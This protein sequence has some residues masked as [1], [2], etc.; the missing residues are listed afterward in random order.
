MNHTRFPL[1][2]AVG[3]LV[4]EF[5][6]DGLC[7][8]RFPARRP[9]SSVP[10]AGARSARPKPGVSRW[11]RLAQDAV[12]AVLAGRKPRQLPPLDLSA[13]TEFQ[14]AVWR[15][16]AEIPAGQTRTYAQMAGRVG[17]PAAARAVGQA[18]GANPIPL[19]IPCHRVLAAQGRLGGFSA[20][21]EWKRLLL[22]REG[23]NPAGRGAA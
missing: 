12:N 8:L 9:S 3:V 17:R 1:R 18:C 7:A 23:L 13:G 6:E 10:R 4:A 20:G 5:S 11:V 22:E 15:A 19:L 16:L 14:Q 21:L 2:T